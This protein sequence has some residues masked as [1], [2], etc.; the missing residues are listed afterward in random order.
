MRKL[1]PTFGVLCLVY[2]IL[3]WILYIAYSNSPKQTDYMGVAI[4]NSLNNWLY[5]TAY[6]YLVNGG[7]V[8]IFLVASG[9]FF[10]LSVK[11]KFEF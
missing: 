6:D 3:S 1:Y 8:A 7:V 9:T 2:P 10:Y 5:T 4:D 11:D